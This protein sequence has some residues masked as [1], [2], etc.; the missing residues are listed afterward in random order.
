MSDLRV[1]WETFE[2]D[3]SGHLRARLRTLSDRVPRTGRADP[4]RIAMNKLGLD[5]PT[6]AEAALKARLISGAYRSHGLPAD[7][8]LI[9]VVE[10][11]IGVWATNDPGPL[12]VDGA[13]VVGEFL[14][15]RVFSSPPPVSAG[16]VTVFAVVVPGVSELEAREA[17]WI[18]RELLGG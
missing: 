8:L 10:T 11:G 14:R 5:D 17:L 12:S 15:V 9:A 6:P 2:A 16:I 3:L 1:V 4:Y 18:A 7:A 13:D